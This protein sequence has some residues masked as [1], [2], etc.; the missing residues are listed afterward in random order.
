MHL[1][2]FITRNYFYDLMS[3]V[4]KLSIVIFKTVVPSGVLDIYR[5]FGGTFFK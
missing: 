1:V 2:G 5:H 4:V 3:T